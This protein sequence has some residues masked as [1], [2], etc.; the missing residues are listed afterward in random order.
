MGS[1]GSAVKSR[2]PFKKMPVKSNFSADS[3]IRAAAVAAGARIVTSSD[4]ASLLKVAQGKNAIHIMPSGVSSIKSPIAASAPAHSEASSSMRN[5]RTSLPAAPL[6][7]NPAVTSS[8]S[9]P[10]SVK[11]ASPKVQHNASSEQSNTVISVPGTELQLK[12]E[13]KAGEETKVSDLCSVSRNEPSKEVQVDTTPLPKPEAELKNESAVA[14]NHESSSN[15]EMV[16]NDQVHISGNQD[17]ENHQHANDDQMLDSQVEKSENQAAVQEN[18]ELQSP[19]NKEAGVPT[20]LNDECSKHL[21]VSSETKP[22]N[23]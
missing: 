8:A 21:E 6:S 3:S 14:E 15:I 20:M 10:G 7:S 5:V 9:Y 22:S 16:E 11:G 1:A 2:V 23:H 4:A 12:P 18:C 17:K 19:N 13:V